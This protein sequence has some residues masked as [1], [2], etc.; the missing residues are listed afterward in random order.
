M[1]CSLCTLRAFTI[2]R[3]LMTM[4]PMPNISRKQEK[5]KLKNTNRSMFVWSWKQTKSINLGGSSKCKCHSLR[6]KPTCWNMRPATDPDNL[7]MRCFSWNGYR[8]EVFHRNSEF[9]W[10]SNIRKNFSLCMLN[11][12]W[13][14]IT[15]S[16]FCTSVICNAVFGSNL[17]TEFPLDE[18]SI[19]IYCK[20]SNVYFFQLRWNE[21]K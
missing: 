4:F 14:I 5:K 12:V 20:S 7:S 6:L 13:G 21:L 11:F 1:S 17:I 16:L 19:R 3:I 18:A 9:S 2:P 10:L 8:P 15:T